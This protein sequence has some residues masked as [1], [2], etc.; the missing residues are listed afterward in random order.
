[1]CHLPPTMSR[2]ISRNLPSCRRCDARGSCL[3]APPRASPAPER[4]ESGRNPRSAMRRSLVGPL[5]IE[6]W[7]DGLPAWGRHGR[8]DAPL[9][10]LF[11]LPIRRPTLLRSSGDRGSTL[12][13][14]PPGARSL[15]RASGSSATARKAGNPRLQ[16]IKL[17][18]QP[19]FFFSQYAEG[20]L[21]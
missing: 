5:G 7:T 19:L 12:G 18:D 2:F 14:Q 17:T 15:P 8:G 4:R 1:C 11:S 10:P 6:P 21:Q 16:G 20:L 9:P 13:A 3:A